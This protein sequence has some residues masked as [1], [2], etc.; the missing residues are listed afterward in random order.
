MTRT[1]TVGRVPDDQ[2]IAK[3]AAKVES[4]RPR[5]DSMIAVMREKFANEPTE[6]VRIREEDGSQFI[7]INGYSY[8]IYPT[9][10]YQDVPKSIADEL[11]NR[12]V[13]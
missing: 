13:I 7:Q 3:P 12:G 6:K 4:E 11:R 9:P 2:I 1:P 8:R 5:R 10:E